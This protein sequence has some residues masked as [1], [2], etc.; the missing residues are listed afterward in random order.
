VVITHFA[1]AKAFFKALNI[2]IKKI[3]FYKNGDEHRAIKSRLR[4][5]AQSLLCPRII[6]FKK[7]P[8]KLSTVSRFKKKPIIGLH[9]STS[10]QT[11]GTLDEKFVLS[12]IK[13]ILDQHM[14]IILFGTQDERKALR[15]KSNPNLIFA[16]HYE[17]I[18]NLALVE[19]CDLLIGAESVFKTMSSMLKIPTLVYHQD[20]NNHFRDRVF[21]NPYIKAGVMSVYKYQALEK[22][23]EPAIDFALQ[24]IKKL[25]ANI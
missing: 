4:K 5:N 17:I 9:M 25:K 24:T 16:S 19:S 7:N 2:H 14:T 18:K 11:G 23:I 10:N 8:F 15:L 13:K 1:K 22:E 12:L 20:N 21:T 3:Y 6:F